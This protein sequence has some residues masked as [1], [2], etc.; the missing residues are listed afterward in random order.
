MTNEKAQFGL[1]SGMCHNFSDLINFRPIPMDLLDL[2]IGKFIASNT[3]SSGSH[4]LLELECRLLDDVES[5]ILLFNE[6]VMCVETS[7]ENEKLLQSL[8]FRFQ[9][10]YNSIC[11]GIYENLMDE[12]RRRRIVYGR[13]EW[14]MVYET[15]DH[16]ESYKCKFEK[17]LWSILKIFKIRHFREWSPKKQLSELLKLN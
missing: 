2:D 12:K 9:L 1:L 6:K 4:K 5:L 14:W 10:K 3:L 7:E 8:I 15:I 13:D 17:L 16:L 11:V